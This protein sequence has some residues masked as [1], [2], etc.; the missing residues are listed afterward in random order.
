MSKAVIVGSDGQDGRIC[1]ELMFE[2]N[3]EFIGISLRGLCHGFSQDIQPMNILNYQQ[4]CELIKSYQPDYIYYFAA[5]HHSSEEALTSPLELLNQSHNINTKGFCNFLEA[6]RE[7]SPKTRIFFASSSLIFEK[8]EEKLVNEGTPYSPSSPYAFS[9]LHSMQISKWYRQN[10]SMHC[11]SGIFFNHE[12][13]FRSPA[14]L[15]RKVIEKAIQIKRGE[16]QNLEVGDLDVKVDWGYARDYVN[17]AEII[18]QQDEPDDYIIATGQLHSV[19]EMIGIVFEYLNLNMETCIKVNPAFLT[20]KRNMYAGNSQK[21]TQKTEWHPSISFS[22]M[23][24]TIVKR[25]YD[26][27]KN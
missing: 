5:Y 19:R 27:K 26:D 12:S 23:V 18:L 15:F 3:I 6:I 1:S 17:A 10:Y 14:F 25:I 20:R 16:E 21:L 13:E 22:E 4:V 9:K 11:S 2:K 8:T 7:F 24:I